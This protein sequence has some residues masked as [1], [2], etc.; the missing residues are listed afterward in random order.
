M[1]YGEDVGK[2]CGKNVGTPLVGT[3]V[4]SNYKFLEVNR[5]WLNRDPDQVPTDKSTPDKGFGNK[6]TYRA[7]LWTKVQGDGDKELLIFNSHYP[8]SAGNKTRLKCAKLEMAKIQK[9]TSGANWVSAGDRNLLPIADDKEQQFDPN[10][11]HE[12]LSKH[13]LSKETKHYGVNTTWLG[14]THEGCK[15]QIKDGKFTNDAKL[16]VIVSNVAQQCTFSLHGAFDIEKQELLPLLGTLTEQHNSSNSY[17]SDHT[18]IG[19]DL[20]L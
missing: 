9:I 14:F 20:V 19:T 5:F 8:L 17:A 12:E 13:N 4:K 18:L 2:W 3:F 15:N 10:I 1:A 11:V 7:V 6:N 16:D